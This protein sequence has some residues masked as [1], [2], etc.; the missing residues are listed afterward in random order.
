MIAPFDNQR[1]IA[2]VVTLLAV[3]LITALVVEFSYGVYIGTS[4]LYNWRDSQ[5]LSLMARSGV[6]IAVKLIE[7]TVN[8]QKYSYP[9][10]FEFPVENPFQGF[11]GMV[12][13]RIE[14]ETSKFNLNA[15][16]PRNQIIRKADEISPYNC[17]KRLLN[18]LSLDEKI[19]DRIVDWIVSNKGS[20]L[21]DSER[22]AQNSGLLSTDEILLIPGISREDYNILL[23]YITVQGTR[24]NLYININGAEKPVLRSLSRDI[25]DDLAEQIVRY[26]E[27]H[28]FDKVEKIW[29]VAGDDIIKFQLQGR[30][31]II[32]D[33]FSI[34]STASTAGV[35]RIIQTV[36]DRDKR[37]IV[38]WKEY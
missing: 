14:D 24:D 37:Q 2:L 29:G 20:R 5:R 30:I 9:G 22:E 35:K 15:L 4:N 8:P 34:S 1:G 31:T 17:F 28:P 19:A 6:N 36:F 21:V 11:N 38:C 23:P 18:L 33:H 13:I 7:D 12:L 3:V 25:S 16:V 26:R 27:E 10:V 32:G